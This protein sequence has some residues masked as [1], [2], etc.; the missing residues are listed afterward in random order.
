ML[1]TFRSTATDPVLMFGDTAT[2]LLRMMGASGKVPGAL[3]AEDVPG[4]LQKLQSALDQLETETAATPAMNQD[5]SA[6]DE[7]G[8]TREPPV[9]LAVRA[10]PLVNL[11]K[12]A[13]AAQAEVAWE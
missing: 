5:R 2:P 9:Q 10:V 4:A 11:L 3:K 1:V 12:R 7:E 13:A 6:E 8:K